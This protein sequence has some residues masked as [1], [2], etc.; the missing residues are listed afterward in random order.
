MDEGGAMRTALLARPGEV[1]DALGDA[2]R[3]AGAEVVLVGDPRSLDPDLLRGCQP[4]AVL[5]ALESEIEDSL[6]RFDVVLHDPNVLVIFDEVQVAAQRMGWDA[7]RWSRHLAAKLNRHHDV[8]PPGADSDDQSLSFP[9]APALTARNA[10]RDRVSPTERTQVQVMDVHS[11]DVAEKTVRGDAYVAPDWPVA[12]DVADVDGTIAAATA[13][14]DDLLIFTD[15]ASVDAISVDTVSIDTGS[16]DIDA[17]A[18]D[19][20][21]ISIGSFQN[22]L[23]GDLSTDDLSLDPD[24]LAMLASEAPAAGNTAGDFAPVDEID[25]TTIEQSV[26]PDA[27][28]DSS[29]PAVADAVTRAAMDRSDA[30]SLSDADAVIAPVAA[31]VHFD[32]DTGSG[33]SLVDP[34]DESVLPTAS[35]NA[36][37]DDDSRGSRATVDLDALAQRASALSL[38]DADTYGHGALRGAVVVEAGLG[39]PDAVRQLLA[40]LPEDFPRPVLVRL[41]LDGGRYDRLVKQMGRASRM[42]VALAQD[43]AAAE[44]GT[45]YFLPSQMG[46]TPR[47]AGLVFVD[48]DVADD[49]WLDALPAADT[50]LLLLSGSDTE[51][52]ERAMAL[53][54]QG[55]LVAGQSSEDCYDHTAAAALIAQGGG[56]GTPAA[57]AAR[58]VDRWA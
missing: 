17:D 13:A 15:A 2:L 32:H 5:V 37:N 42:P 53:S 21:S 39:G 50:A 45:A 29:A 18:D 41:Q 51:R 3:Q 24:V 23:D 25:F 33:L 48:Q 38:A 46:V 40:G 58:L 49:A 26:D 28:L 4:Q 10:T 9:D 6:D 22:D 47:G 1:C 35:A 27:A 16:V 7:A 12:G 55:A 56:H 36:A 44:P 30:L 31:A 11:A 20:D 19:L 54:A 43:G 57:L 34:D 8:L 52:V 14:D